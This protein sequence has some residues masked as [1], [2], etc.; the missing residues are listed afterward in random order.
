[1]ISRITEPLKIIFWKS[2][3][4]VNVKHPC[5]LISY[6]HVVKTET[7]PSKVDLLGRY[8]KSSA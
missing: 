5:D 3:Q 2:L 1:M 6:K 7:L 8:F 4:W